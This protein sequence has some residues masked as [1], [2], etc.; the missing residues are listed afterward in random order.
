M[1]RYITYRQTFLHSITPMHYISD[2]HC[3]GFIKKNQP[4]IGISWRA[5]WEMLHSTIAKKERRTSRI[6]R[7]SKKIYLPYKMCQ[8]LNDWGGGGGGGGRRMITLYFTTPRLKCASTIVKT[9]FTI[10]KQ[11]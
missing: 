11:V 3:I 2:I 1:K 4:W 10:Y 7:E 8:D 5:R 9:M 6:E